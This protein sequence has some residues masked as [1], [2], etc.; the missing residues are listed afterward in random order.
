M[1][2]SLSPSVCVCVAGAWNECARDSINL[3]TI[4]LTASPI[5]A[6][7]AL[8]GV[9][10]ASITK[11][12]HNSFKCRL[13]NNGVAS[14]I[15]IAFQNPQIIIYK[16]NVTVEKLDACI[17]LLTPSLRVPTC[18]WLQLLFYCFLFC[19]VSNRFRVKCQSNELCSNNITI[20]WWW[21]WWFS[22]SVIHSWPI[23]CGR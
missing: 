20:I 9:Q 10:Y 17:Y 22:H 19:R 21:W 15:L 12:M 18:V 4:Y 23:Q 3:L 6:L 7:C 8:N 1:I 14:I 5:C 11:F 2:T 16:L 13:Y